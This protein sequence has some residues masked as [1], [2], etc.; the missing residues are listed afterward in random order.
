[1]STAVPSKRRSHSF[2]TMR[3][4][5]FVA[6]SLSAGVIAAALA[7]AA[8]PASADEG[9]VSFWLPGQFGSLAAAPGTPGW[10]LP[11][12]YYHLDANAGA[13]KAFQIGGHTDLGIDAK[14][15]LGILVPTYTFPKPMFGSGQLA[16]AMTV[17]TGGMNVSADLTLTGPGGNTL[18]V[19]QTD[20]SSGLG[21][22][23]PS[24]QVRWNKG[25]QNCLAYLMGGIPVGDYEKGRLAN[26]SSNHGAI[27]LGGGYTYLNT[28]NGRE[29]S[30]TGGF[31]FNFK[32]PDTDYQ[33]GVDS[34]LDLGLSQFLSAD[35]HIGAVGYVYYQLSGDTGDGAVLGDFKSKVYGAGPQVG[36]IFPIGGR[37]VYTNVKAFWEWG[38]EHRV[39]GSNFWLTFVI[40]L[41]PAAAPAE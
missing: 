9:G 25:T 6:R 18:G 38:A 30:A 28:K 1:M 26:L 37:K 36:Y 3:R 11:V 34:H 17:V 15:D 35:A 10:S 21:D 39:E 13:T 20:K 5:S 27:D 29:L 33:N 14:A 16:L 23:Y 19:N 12:V 41:T 2:P 4:A 40:P 32:N 7:L 22:L 31:T 8:W 24:A